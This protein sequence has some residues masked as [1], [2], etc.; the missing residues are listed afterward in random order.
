M[1]LCIQWLLSL[2]IVQQSV[3]FVTV[4]KHASVPF[5]LQQFNHACA[6]PITSLL[7]DTERLLDKKTVGDR[8]TLTRMKAA[9]ERLKQLLTATTKSVETFCVCEAIDSCTAF[10][11]GSSQL[12]VKKRLKANEKC[13]VKGSKILLSE[14]IMCLCNNAV[15]AYEPEEASKTVFIDMYKDSQS[16]KI[17][18]RD[19]GRGMS[20]FE[21][22]CAQLDGVSCHKKG[23]GLGIP[24]C[25]KTLHEYFGG[26]L[27][28][29]SRK[30]HGTTVT[31][32][33]P[34]YSDTKE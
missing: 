1:R 13:I 14:V 23:S 4:T 29:E 7:L 8:K 31:L 3:S 22:W 15:E 17:A 24:F 30:G 28:I 10:F 26:R 33:L 16:I 11:T 5:T 25:V 2:P 27:W 6:S 21:L 34:S 32:S 12:H 9:T 19:Y 20:I 18:I